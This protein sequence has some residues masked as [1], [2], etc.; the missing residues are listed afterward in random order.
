[1]EKKMMILLG[2]FSVATFIS[3]VICSCLV[4]YNEKARTDI[5]SNKVL[6][7]TD[8][9]KSTSI[10][11]YSNNNLNLSQLQPG[12]TL[13]QKFSITNN[14]SNQINYDIV[15]NNISS[16]WNIPENGLPAYPDEFVYSLT[17]TDGQ[18]VNAS[19]PT[20]ESNMVILENQE[21]K[22]NK[23]NEC[24]IKITFIANG[25]DQSYNLNKSFGG[26]YK[27]VVKD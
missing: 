7:A 14:N 4:F 6:A 25:Y 26:E 21:L 23:T 15:W 13:E 17:C 5:N 10:N 2:F 8:I 24:T 9:N 22:T 1:M 20:N 11:Y 19:M 16:T 3:S 18:K 12:Y 27:V